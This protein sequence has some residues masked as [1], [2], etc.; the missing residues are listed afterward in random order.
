MIVGGTL[1]RETGNPANGVGVRQW[2]LLKANLKPRA[3]NSDMSQLLKTSIVWASFI[4]P[5]L[6][7]L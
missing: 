3:K 7:S 2:L 4:R 6:A 1:T 5:D